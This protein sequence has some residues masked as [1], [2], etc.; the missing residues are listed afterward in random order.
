LLL[1]S[2]VKA[3]RIFVSLVV[4]HLSHQRKIMTQP[5]KRSINSS[6]A[7]SATPDEN[8]KKRNVKVQRQ[9]T[10]FFAAAPATTTTG[11]NSSSPATGAPKPPLVPVS[12]RSNDDDDDDEKD[13][14]N[15]SSFKDDDDDEDDADFELLETT[16]KKA[17]AVAKNLTRRTTTRNNTAATTATTKTT[18]PPPKPIRSTKK[19]AKPDITTDQDEEM[20]ES[21]EASQKDQKQKKPKRTTTKQEA[22]SS[23]SIA[24]TN[25]KKKKDS[26]TSEFT[27][28]LQKD[29]ANYKPNNNPQKWPGAQHEYVDPVGLDPTHGIVESILSTQVSKIAKLLIC[30]STFNV[31]NPIR[32]QTACSG[33]DAPS[34]ALGMVQ[35]ILHRNNGTSNN[36]TTTN[37]NNPGGH[38]QQQDQQQEQQAGGFHY[39]HEMSCEMEPFKQAYI[40]RNFPG[41]T[42]F[43]DICKLTATDDDNDNAAAS[44][45]SGTVLDVYGRPQSI[46]T[47]NLFVAG[48][49]CKDFSMLKATYRLDIEDKGTSGET[50]LAAVDFLQRQQPSMAI[51][52]NVDGAP[53]EKMQEYITGYCKLA[54]RNDTK[55]IVI[56]SS[57]KSNNADTE[58]KFSVQNDTYVAEA[59]PR[60]VGIQAGA[61]VQGFIR[62]I[63]TT[64]PIITMQPNQKDDQ[65]KETDGT[66][67]TLGQLAKRHGIDLARDTLVMHQNVRYCTHLCK[68]DSKEYGL[69]QTRNRK[70]RK[71]AFC[72][73]FFCSLNL[74]FAFCWFCF[75]LDQY[76]FL[77][78]TEDS[79]DNDLGVYFQEILDHL[80]TKL[81]YSMDA[82]LLPDT[83]DRIRCFR[84]ALRSGPGLLVQRE[85]AKE[86]DFWDW[87][88]AH[89]KDLT[90]HLVYREKNGIQERSRW[91]T[92]WNTRGRKQLA[93]G[94]WPELFDCWNMRRLDMVDCFAAASGKSVWGC[95]STRIRFAQTM[96]LPLTPLSLMHLD[97][98]QFI[99]VRDA[100]SRDP[101]HHS[102]TWD[103]SQNVTRAPFRSA[104]CGVSGC[105]TPGGELLLPHKGRT[106]MGYEKLLLQGTK[107][108]HDRHL[109]VQRYRSPLLTHHRVPF[110]FSR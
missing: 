17:A 12:S 52:E 79:N 16:T 27:T 35:E 73:C 94:L 44:S 81:L 75:T 10:S 102:F 87:D 71:N 56:G 42:L 84:E 21:K 7:S 29:R 105:V 62:G 55:A 24:A 99:L 19:R 46:P 11:S 45:G 66:L 34:I 64:H 83:N 98:A 60:Q 6:S 32:L 88:L 1:L 59:V 80:K 15:S 3:K 36:T 101:L 30:N 5:K 54:Q 23:S 51:F 97:L 96:V 72:H 20:E 18:G 93:P 103:L 110:P 63:D 58:L 82:F 69:P 37:N 100:I 68:L 104:T 85:R 40:A 70:V 61:S 86:L 89:V 9:L 26:S 28:K 25:Q 91:L 2:A 22:S 4:F 107:K 38:D 57:K 43:P 74:D 78:K 50:F 108:T 39:S 41:V 92:E 67:L 53:W 65:K 48:T 8:N 109:F 76:L 49:S 106:V 14:S 77:W 31:T 95:W 33:T 90:N 13:D 47:G